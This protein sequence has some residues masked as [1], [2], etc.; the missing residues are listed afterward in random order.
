MAEKEM[1]EVDP[2]PPEESAPATELADAK[3]E[4]K[5]RRIVRIVLW[6]VIVLVVLLAAAVLV[7]DMII[8][9]AIRK[10]GSQA[11]GTT[12]EVGSFSSSLLRGRVELAGLRVANP[13]GYRNPDAIVFDRIVVQV[14]P[15]SL[16]SDVIE[17][18][19]I[20][21][22]G[23]RVDFEATLSGSNLT[24]IQKNIE[25]FAG[26]SAPEQ[27]EE[28]KPEAK[29]EAEPT[30]GEGDAAGKQVLIHQLV[31]A[32]N[33]LTLSSAMLQS[34][35]PLLLPDIRMSEVGGGQP[36]GETMNQMM[37][38]LMQAISQAV[39]QAGINAENIQALGDSLSR[40]GSDVLEAGAEAL[41]QG[42]GAV[43]DAGENVRKAFDD[44]AE[45]VKGAGDD[46]KKAIDDVSGLFKKK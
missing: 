38:T 39:A 4:R 28:A 43:R 26:G 45:A 2:V 14:R 36:L 15:G 17:V 13:P 11:T 41:K 33:S 40:A 16:L 30:A 29:S 12:V 18:D 9:T 25:T 10:V 37:I 34:T 24:D 32:D 21:V 44:G 22:D 42:S 46:I 19:E 5:K 27:P 3:L 31:V 8:E 35:L 23:M 6:V 1:R 7:R 20:R